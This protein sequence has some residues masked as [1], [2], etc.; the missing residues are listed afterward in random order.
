MAKK[1]LIANRGEIALRVIR[2]CKELGFKTV[3][4]YS[5]ADS[6]S[7]HVKFADEAICI[8]GS[9]ADE[10]YLNTNNI[11]S[12]AIAT[13]A[14]AI[15]PGY[16]FLSENA[17]FIETIEKN[18]I[19]FIGPNSSIVRKIGNKI[20]AK[21]VASD[22]GVPIIKGSSH[23]VSSSQEASE[24]AHLLGLP[25]QFKA[26][27]GG[28]GKGIRSVYK[29]E[30]ISQVFA[31][32]Q[33]ESQSSFGDSDIYL[34]KLIENCKHIEIQIIGDKFGNLVHLGER[35]CSIQVRNQKIVEEARSNMDSS[36]LVK[37]LTL[38]AI[39]I[40]KSIGYTNAGTVEFLVDNYGN[41]FFLE[42]NPR[43]Q[44]EHAVTEFITDID[45][46]KEQI[47]IA[48]GNKLSFSQ[49]HVV[50]SGHSIECRV[51]MVDFKEGNVIRSIVFPGGKGIRIDTHI[52]SGYIIPPFYDSL[53]LKLIV[54]GR[55][56]HESVSR[57]K[58]ALEQLIVDGV[59]TNIETLYKI[60]HSKPFHK[61]DYNTKL[62]ESELTY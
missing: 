60:I 6:E 41:Y 29:L 39:E 38:D 33:N 13:S 19:I 47:Q 15:H 4:V 24:I 14:D 51:N 52:Y 25:I 11:I 27:N 35:E 23:S 45:I 7:L 44:V 18:K 54:H 8:G 48:F 42:I 20:L 30:E 58:V 21:Q 12:A 46:V 2:A 40:M 31:L 50:F 32:V 22:L 55:T 62:L 16:G 56:R 10:S 61:G 49:D 9:T 28:G 5:E 17:S 26:A 43:L 36:E 1:I 57:M 37:Q 3:A 53:L 34:E 59:N